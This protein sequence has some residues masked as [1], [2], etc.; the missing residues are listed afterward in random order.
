MGHYNLKRC[1]QAA[2][3]VGVTRSAMRAA[4][5]YLQ[6]RFE[7]NGGIPFQNTLFAFANLYSRLA[8]AETLPYSAA[9]ET[10]S[11]DKIGVPASIAKYVCAELA[12]ETTSRL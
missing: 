4:Y 3:A 6:N 8:S 2:I 11:A 10:M 1:R 7:A 9:M 5:S 12:V